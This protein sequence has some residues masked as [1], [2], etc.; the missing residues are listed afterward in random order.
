MRDDEASIGTVVRAL[1]IDVTTLL[2]AARA[3]PR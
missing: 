2:Y 1:P 3:E